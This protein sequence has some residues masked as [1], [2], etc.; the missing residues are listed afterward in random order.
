[1]ILPTPGELLTGVHRELRDQVLSELP[2]GVAT[3][4][5]RAA[6]HVLEQV[7]RSWD[8]QHGYIVSDN[9]DLDETLTT[10]SQLLGRTRDRSP[11][12]AQM[13]AR[14]ASTDFD[15]AVEV[16]IALQTELEKIQREIR[17]TSTRDAR[18]RATLM[19]LHTRMVHRAE[20]AL[21]VA[22]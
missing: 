2:P 5:M 4:Q 22:E 1:M 17:H 20:Y 9:A 7:A 10:L 19:A 15:E 16:N 21:G 3:R 8:R 12:D 13:T 14:A 6:L 11:H 18:A